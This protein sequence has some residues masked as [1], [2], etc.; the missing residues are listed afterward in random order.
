MRLRRSTLGRYG[1]QGL[2]LGLLS[3]I[4]L[5][6]CTDSMIARFVPP[7]SDQRARA[8]L[9]LFTQGQTDAAIKRLSAPLQTADAPVQLEHLTTLLRGQIFDSIRIIGVQV[10]KQSDEQHVNLSYQLHSQ[11]GWSVANVA[12]VEHDSVWSVEGV[13][14]IP[15]STSLESINAF[16]FRGR[17]GLHYIWLGLTCIAVLISIGVALWVSRAQTMPKRWWWVFLALIGVGQGTLNWTTGGWAVRPVS[18]L[19]LSAA[20]AKGGPVAP[21]MISFSIP[22][23]AAI[24]AW[25]YLRWRRHNPVGMSTA[26]VPSNV[27]S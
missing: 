13:S 1:V 16:T 27:V 7:G 23:G 17:S 6:A 18:V 21:W 8:Y 25:K 20:C 3:V 10:N 19:L 5:G 26:A 2:F 4:G 9:A 24:T 22:V 14:A 11:R 15:T 12:T